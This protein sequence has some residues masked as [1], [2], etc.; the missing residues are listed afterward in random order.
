MYRERKG[1]S[2]TAIKYILHLAVLCLIGIGINVGMSKLVHVTGIP[3]YLDAIGTVIV[4]FV[5]GVLPGIVVGLATNFIN[6]LSD[7]SAIFYGTLNVM[8]AVCAAFFTRN[9]FKKRNMIPLVVSLAIIGGVL[10]SVLTWFIYGFGS[11]GITADLARKFYDTWCGNRYIAQMSADF[12]IDLCD[13]TITVVIAFI[14]ARFISKD[15]IEWLKGF[16]WQQK[17]LTDEQLKKINKSH[18]R[19]MSIRAKILILLSVAIAVIAIAAVT[20]GYYIFKQSTVSDHE[21]FGMGIV[22]NCSY[23]LDPEMVDTYIEQGEDAPG[24]KETYDYFQKFQQSSDDIEYLYVYQIREDGCH[25]VFDVD[26]EDL[27]GGNPGDVVPF[28]ESFEELKDDLI[29]GK[30]IEPKVTNDTYGWL[31]TIYKPIYNSEGRCVC[32]IGVDISMHQLEHSIYGYLAKQISLFLGFFILVLCA[33]LWLANYNIIYPLNAMSYVA[34]AFAYN[35]TAER[36]ESVKRITDLSIHTGDELENLYTAYERTT[37]ESMLFL[38][39]SRRKSKVI[40]KLQTGLI[41]VLADMVE[42]RD[43]GTGDH[44]KKTAA[45]T[46]IIL[47]RLKEK[48][49]FPDIITGSYIDDVVKSAP[50]HDIGKISVPDAILNKPGR[51]EASEYEI[52]KNHTVAGSDIIMKVIDNVSEAG[53][54][55]EAKNLARFHHEKYDGTG[56]PT[57]LKGEEIPL[58][59]RVMAVADVFDALVSRRSYKDPMSFDEVM[60]IIIDGKGTHF[61]PKVVDAFVDMKEEVRS[62]AEAFNNR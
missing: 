14:V 3:L 11:E 23:Y 32:Y 6:S 2:S 1:L 55:E 5:G 31:L 18:V 54:L 35:S 27:E 50:L 26:T 25:V 51:L 41:M 38:N 49:E 53:Y 34:S 47:I 62:V 12:L 10:G 44:I 20:I 59:A 39:E 61:D 33:G 57:G 45:Y 40:D 56:Y 7:Y 16:G 17:R 28:D 30:P 36:N 29:A 43:K 46:S 22:T 42:S 4:S 13:K 58:S 9:G 52:M 37:V 48:G 21:Q 19:Q 8:I 60:Q 15:Y 24:Y